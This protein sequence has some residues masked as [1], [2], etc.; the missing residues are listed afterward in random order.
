MLAN[1]DGSWSS[2]QYGAFPS[3]LHYLAARW[4]GEDAEFA[5]L[6]GPLRREKVNT[7]DQDGTC[8]EP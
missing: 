8:R 4:G 6:S 2:E 5:D 7:T 1:R 3:P